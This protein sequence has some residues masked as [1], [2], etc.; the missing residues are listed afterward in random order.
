MPKQSFAQE[1]AD[2]ESTLAAVRSNAGHFPPLVHTVAGE[3]EAPLT[4]ELERGTR[5]ARDI[6]AYVLLAFGPKNPRVTG[7]GIRI[8]RRPRRRTPAAP[9]ALP[10]PLADVP[11]AFDAA[12]QERRTAR[13]ARA[14]DAEN[15]ASVGGIRGNAGRNG[16]DG[17]GLGGNDPGLWAAAQP[18]GAVTARMGERHREIGGTPPAPGETSRPAGERRSRRPDVRCHESA[19]RFRGLSC[20]Y[21]LLRGYA[22][23]RCSSGWTSSSSTDTSFETPFSSMV[24]P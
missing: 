13:P 2:L 22:V 6:R 8:R 21:T 9:P 17:P 5:A 18:L 16:G 19:A 24:T 3:L 20:I 10:G 1:I 4:A 14:N 23:A 11:E 15:G 7:F 12:R